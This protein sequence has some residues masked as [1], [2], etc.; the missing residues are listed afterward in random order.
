MEP[1]ILIP[2]TGKYL[3]TNKTLRGSLCN[4]NYNFFINKASNLGFISTAF[5]K[6]AGLVKNEIGKFNI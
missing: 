1:S 4:N 5:F 2:L 6:S 3:L